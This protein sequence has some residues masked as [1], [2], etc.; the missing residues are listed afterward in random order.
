MC[1]YVC[2][3]VRPINSGAVTQGAFEQRG[4]VF[5]SQKSFKAGKR[6]DLTVC[7]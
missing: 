4:G 6:I 1:V 2:V 5:L 3:C 7:P